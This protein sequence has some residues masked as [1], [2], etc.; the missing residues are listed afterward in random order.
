MR[1]Y[2]VGTTMDSNSIPPTAGDTPETI[3]RPLRIAQISKADR[4][5]GGASRVAEELTALLNGSG[6]TSHHWLSWSGTQSGE[7]NRSL[8]GKFPFPIRAFNHVARKIGFAEPIPI[9]LGPLLF[10]GRI[11]QYDVVHFHDLSS[12]ISPLTLLWLARRMPVV[13]TIHDC[14]PFTGGCLYPI[15]CK[16]FQH[17]C[18]SCP[19]LGEWPIDGR[20][21]FT[22]VQ[23]RRKGQLAADGRINYITPS[24][25]MAETAMSSGLFS[26]AP[27]VVANGVDTK[28]FRPADKT[29]IRRQLGLPQDRTVVLLAAGS[30]LDVRKGA[31]HAI[32]ALLEVRDRRPVV[33]MV[34]HSAPQVR[35]LL[36]G[37]DV[38]ESGYISDA[39]ELARHYAAA[40]L[41]LFTSLADNQP[42][43]VLE[44][45]A[46][47]TPIVGFQTGG[48][49]EMVVQGETGFLVPQKD[50]AALS[51][52]LAKVLDDPGILRR[53]GEY[54]RIRADRMFSH[55]RFL[56]SHMMLYRQL[57]TPPPTVT[58]SVSPC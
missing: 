49:P 31:R 41:F 53:W 44:T 10:C 7:H 39:G 17:S 19:Q 32:E 29:A 46:A 2:D 33:L 23:R 13:W 4:F 12:A 5:G 58:G 30:L 52:C 9:E 16:R 6:H 25:W 8:Y 48:I 20:L 18:G 43:A 1:S 57:L 34:G 35:E 55:E 56:Q 47:G 28:L 24:K 40:D 45:M 51:A 50:T 27:Q 37:F 3:D 42:L 54:G 22:A 15:D 14:S 38:F 11:W 26:K 21:D 36:A